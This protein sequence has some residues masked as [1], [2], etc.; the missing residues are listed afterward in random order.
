MSRSR[1]AMDS[2]S[3]IYVAGHR[4]L[5][6][7]AIVRKLRAVGCT[8]IVVREFSELDLR[9]REAVNRF[10]ASEKPEYVFLAAAKVGGIHANNTYKAEFIYDNLAIAANVIDA[11][12]RFGVKKLLNL[13]SSCIYPKLAPQ[14]LKEEYLLTGLLEATN[15]PYAIAK[16]AAIKL[17]RYYNEQYGTNFISVMPTNL[18]GPGD[19]FNLETS[20]VL[21]ALMRKIHLAHLLGQGR[22]VEIRKDVEKR[23][24]GFGIVIMTETSE[25]ELEAALQRLG[26]HR[27]YVQLWGTGSAL[28]EFLF[29][30]D[31]ADAVVHLM[32]HYNANDIGEFVNI[33]VG[34]DSSIK[35]LANKI[36][37]IVG[38]SGEIR[39]DPTKPDGTPR[40]LLDISRIKALGWTPRITLDDGLKLLYEWYSAL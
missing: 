39:F 29:S 13:G 3:K 2:G 12:Y 35:D 22:I 37:S 33:G 7:S 6:G 34:T 15:E 28:R 14:P 10:F 9:E 38:Y 36:K 23:A 8:N 40:K 4:G 27:T 17:C 19:N 32:R 30:D 20:H 31:L 16:I 21:P 11:S 24:L 1:K 25:S 5:V 26:I 18:F